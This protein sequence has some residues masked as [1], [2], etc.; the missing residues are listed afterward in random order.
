MACVE[1]AEPCGTVGGVTV[2][3][4]LA[5]VQVV[6]LLAA[7][8][9]LEQAFPT[10]SHKIK[11]LSDIHS[12]K[13]DLDIAFDMIA[14]CPQAS[15]AADAG[16]PWAEHA[17]MAMMHSAIVFYARATKSK[18]YHR[19]TFDLR[20]RLSTEERA[21]HDLLCHLRDDAVAHYG[22][23]PLPSGFAFHEEILLL[24]VD[25][26]EGNNLLMLSRRTCFAPDFVAQFS[27]HLSR[28]LLLAQREAQRREVDA[29][30]DISNHPDKATLEKVLWA[31][32]KSAAEAMG[33]A[34]APDVV[35][36]GPRA[37][38]RTLYQSNAGW[39]ERG[40]K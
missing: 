25:R 13:A 5:D 1:R 6:D 11:R 33:R 38:A 18:S 7:A 19:S 12:I 2:Q 26:P 37:G 22:P 28:A 24:P 39:V 9:E 35:L 20:T 15:R 40:Q 36:S 8:A 30:R 16:S 32:V 34:D 29:L 23:G 14:A 31:H 3:E 4:P 21:L 17:G 27:R 10:V